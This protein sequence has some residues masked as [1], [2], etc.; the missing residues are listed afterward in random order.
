[1]GAAGVRRASCSCWSAGITSWRV[2]RRRMKYETW[3]VTHLYFYLAIALAYLHQVTPRPAV[4]DAHLGAVDLDRPLPDHL[5]AAAG[6]PRRAAG[7][8]LA[9]ARPE[10][11]RRRP[12][13]RR[14]HQRLDQR[15]QPRRARRARRPVLRLALPHPAPLVAVAPL[16]DLDRPRRALP[17][18]HGQGPRR[19][20]PRPRGP[21]ARHPR[22][23]RGPVRRLHRRR[24]AH[25]PRRCSS[26]A[27]WGSHPSRSVLDDLPP[28]VPRRPPVPRP[29]TAR[30]S[31]CAT[32][33]RRSPARGP[34]CALRYLVGS[35]RDYP[36]NARTL[37]HLVPD[38]RSRDIYTCGP[39]A[40]VDSVRHAA[41]V[42]RMP[43]D[44]IHD[45]SFSFHSPDYYSFTTVEGGR[46]MKRAILVGG[47]TLAGVAA[48][49]ALNPD[50]TGTATA[51]S[52]ASSA[53]SGTTP[54][55]R[56]V[57]LRFQLGQRHRRL[58]VVVRRRPRRATAPTRA[59]SSTSATTTATSRSRSPSPAVA[60]ST[61]RPSRLPQNDRRSSQ[62]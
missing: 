53:S 10:G 28:H 56:L 21:D 42:L 58:G 46:A 18:H 62:I 43:S 14:H 31:S 16:L 36:I 19:P 8:A 34:A 37:L 7:L 15:P 40:L 38:V 44:Q 54:G 3:W 4:R 61:S 23:G 6:L 57:V 45:D 30:P 26:P 41:E 27:A 13:V 39:D 50:A 55:E 35:R 52:T 11:A 33:S 49:L 29:A 25:R 22:R 2:A 32:S 12:R 60:S 51:S 20:Q 1:M 48:V 59:T 5:R 47:G 9:A 24:A 17:A